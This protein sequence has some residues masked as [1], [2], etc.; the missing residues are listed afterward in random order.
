[1]GSQ[2]S[3]ISQAKHN[4]SL[5]TR[6]NDGMMEYKDWI[7]IT[8]F[9]SAVHYVESVRATKGDHSANHAERSNF[10]RDSYK[11]NRNFRN[12]YKSLKDGAWEARYLHDDVSRTDCAKDYYDE[13]DVHGLLADLAFVKTILKVS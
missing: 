1:M 4:E 2:A 3:H 5:A 6:L 9:Y 11:S 10:I 12:A 13:S 7:L 8:L